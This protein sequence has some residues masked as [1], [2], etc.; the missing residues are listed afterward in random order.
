MRYLKFYDTKAEY[1]HQNPVKK[2][3]FSSPEDWQFSSANARIHGYS[4]LIAL[5]DC[6]E[7][8]G[9]IVL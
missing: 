6:H 3:Y 9:N 2:G 5:S 8:E 7:C 1:I 4:N